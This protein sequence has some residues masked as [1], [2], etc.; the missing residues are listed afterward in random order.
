MQ[1]RLTRNN[2]MATANEL[3]EF[4]RKNAPVKFGQVCIKKQIAPSTLY[5]YM[6]ILLSVYE[7]IH[8][9]NGEFIVNGKVNSIGRENL[10]SKTN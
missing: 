8:Y 5:N 4:I 9:A 10:K 1:S 7:D 3:A 2:V 6:K